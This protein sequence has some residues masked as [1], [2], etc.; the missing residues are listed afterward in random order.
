MVREFLLRNRKTLFSKAQVKAACLS[1]AQDSVGLRS[2][3]NT[4][5]SD[6]RIHRRIHVMLCVRSLGLVTIP[7]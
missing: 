4:Q 3:K 7:L 5:P 6:R 1:G 2:Y